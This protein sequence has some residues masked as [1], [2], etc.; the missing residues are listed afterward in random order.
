VACWWY[1]SSRVN[2]LDVPM[3]RVGH[4][5]V[6]NLWRSGHNQYSDVR[7]SL[8]LA[9]TRLPLYSLRNERRYPS[10][11]PVVRLNASE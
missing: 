3:P 10:P 1:R 5:G 4:V 8:K 2:Q 11:A 6:T 7:Y 9:G